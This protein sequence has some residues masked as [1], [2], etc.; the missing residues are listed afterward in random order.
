MWVEGRMMVP[1]KDRASPFSSEMTPFGVF[2]RDELKP[3]QMEDV[4]EAFFILE[5][6][7]QDH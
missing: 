7:P 1:D 6:K 4:N 5:R 2:Y 3:Q